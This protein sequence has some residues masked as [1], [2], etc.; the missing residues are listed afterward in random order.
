MDSS[1]ANG[2]YSGP[3]LEITIDN[4]GDYIIGQLHL[5]REVGNANPGGQHER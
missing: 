2:I 3:A 4:G 5:H 1:S